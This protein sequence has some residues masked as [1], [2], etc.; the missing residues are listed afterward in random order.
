MDI[1][2]NRCGEPWDVDTFHDVADDLG[3]SFDAALARFYAD[4][5]AGTG[6]VKRCD[7]APDGPARVRA[8]VSGMLAEV[9]GDDVD[10]IASELADAEF[11][12]WLS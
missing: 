4:G 1:Y 3:V 11:F 2:C 6:W 12:G 7:V 9:L 5:C 10:G 8:S